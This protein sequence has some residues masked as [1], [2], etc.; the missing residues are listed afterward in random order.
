MTERGELEPHYYLLAADLTVQSDESYRDEESLAANWATWTRMH[1]DPVYRYPWTTTEEFRQFRAEMRSAAGRANLSLAQRLRIA[2]RWAG[3][4]W[5][6]TPGAY[7]R[8]S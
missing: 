6:R 1:G 2:A 8:K 3:W 5:T 7:R 4:R